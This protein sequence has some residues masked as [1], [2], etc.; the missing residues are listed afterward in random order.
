MLRQRVISSIV[1]LVTFGTFYFFLD[2]IFFGGLVIFIGGF[3][4]F[5]LSKILK[6]KGISAIFY[7]VLAALP[8]LNYFLLSSS[9]SRSFFNSLLAKYDTLLIHQIYDSYILIFALFTLFFWFL[10]VPIDIIYK[11]ISSNPVIKVFYGIIYITPMLLSLLFFFYGDKDFLIMLILMICLADIGGYFV[12]KN[13]GSIKIAKKISPGKT[14]EGLLGGFVCNIIFVFFWFSYLNLSLIEGFLLAFLVTA[15][16]LY[17][18]IYESFLKRMAKI[19]D[20]S[21]LIPGHGGFLDRLDSFCP[22]IPILYITFGYLY[23]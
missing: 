6:I 19:K 2:P 3:L 4:V 23:I 7:W 21:S 5:E 17:G 11:K 9:Y 8:M 20:S 10:I 22:T 18:D 13:F 15:L 1:M 12:G 16:S 14:F